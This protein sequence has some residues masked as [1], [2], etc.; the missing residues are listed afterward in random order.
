M[1]ECPNCG[2]E[3]S[4]GDE[5]CQ[6]CG[7]MFPFSTDIMTPSTVLQ[8]RYEIQELTHTGG[9][10]YVYLAKDKK[11][12]DRI[13]IVKQVKEPVKSDTEL[14]KKLQEEA[15]SMTKLSHPNVAMILDH[16]VEGDYYFLVVEYISGKSLSEV[17]EEHHGKLT[18]EEVVNWA[19]SMCDVVQFF[20]EQDI[21]HRDISPQNIMLTDK[22]IIKFIDFGTLRELRDIAT[23]G[24][25]GMGKFGYTPP[26]QWLG[27]PVAQSDVFALGAT[28]YHLLT[29]FLPLSEEFST[30]QRLQGQDFTP[31]FPPIRQENSDI[32][33]E[34]E[35]ILQK[36]LELGINRRYSSAAKFGQALRGIGTA[37]AKEVT[38][39][40][41]DCERLDFADIRPGSHDAKSFTLRNTGTSR[42]SGKITTN[43]PWLKIS[44]TAIDLPESGE[45]KVLVTVDVTG[46]DSGFSG[47]GDINITTDGGNAKVSVGLSTSTAT[48]ARPSAQAAVPKK[49]G[50]KKW[51][52]FL[53]A[54]LI[55]LVVLL[56][57]GG[58]FLGLLEVSLPGSPATSP[59]AETAT[60]HN[61]QGM[62]FDEAGQYDNA[63]AEYTRAIEVDS[64]Y[65]EA[66][67]NRGYA[68]S[69]KGEYDNAIADYTRAIELDSEYAGAYNNR[70]W[71]YYLKGEYD[72]AI[73]DYARAIELDPNFALSYT[74]RGIAYNTQSEYDKAIA[75]FNKVVDLNPNNAESFRNR[76]WAYYLKEEYSR[77][78]ADYT[79]SIQLDP[80]Y[81]YAYYNRG[82]AYY[83]NEQY[84]EAIDDFTRAIE[85]NPSYTN[86]YYSQ[87]NA[88]KAVNNKA[89]AVTALEKFIELSQDESLIEKARQSL[90]DL[91][92][93]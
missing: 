31:D 41:T 11:L 7:Y 33:P 27:K 82:N 47:T 2:K 36:S 20:H 74:R 69:N 55:V 10:G 38:A 73:T 76:G 25:S 13:C 71:A 66:Y 16:F 83:D 87:A 17:L 14:L 78:I 24:T 81:I 44:P 57:A 51:P 28:I 85:I 64:N 12:Y 19:V 6:H 75:D 93:L 84:H 5:V 39:L 48:A 3:Y 53:V 37:K 67:S 9:M 50:R 26:E 68:Y 92:G 70:G 42:L 72:N 62:A 4:P 32:S 59:T 88:Y 18:E 29:G 54:G 46:L 63:I 80:S 40:S 35:A 45:E 34:L 77:A 52:I 56:I 43:Q 30:S 22:G 91:Q 65:A 60:Q 89:K 21:I 61:E 23:K 15:F 49:G 1:S 90:K 86:A 79:S 8:D 58:Q